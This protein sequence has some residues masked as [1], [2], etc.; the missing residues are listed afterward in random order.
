MPS[1]RRSPGRWSPVRHSWVPAAAP[2][3]SGLQ[4]CGYG[5][6]E[7]FVATL[8]AVGVVISARAPDASVEAIELPAHPFV[9]ATL[10]QRMSAR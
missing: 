3:R 4:W 6:A 1:R 2:S 8:E 7:P 5:L 9:L 10:F